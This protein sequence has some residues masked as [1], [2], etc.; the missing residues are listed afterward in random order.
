MGREITDEKLQ[1]YFKITEEALERLEIAVHEK[2]LL[3]SVARDFLTMARSYF[4]DARYYYERGRLRD[5]FRRSQ[6]CPRV[7]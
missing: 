6:L 3:M 4:E 1:K 7:Y 2:S 5:R